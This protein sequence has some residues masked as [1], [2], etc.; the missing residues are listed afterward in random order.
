MLIDDLLNKAIKA[1]KKPYWCDEH[2]KWEKEPHNSKSVTVSKA[3]SGGVAP[4][5]TSSGA[6]TDTAKS[7]RM[8]AHEEVVPVF[9]SV[10]KDRN[11][12]V[13]GPPGPEDAE[14]MNA[15]IAAKKPAKKPSWLS[16]IFGRNKEA[17]M[18]KG[19]ENKPRFRATQRPPGTGLD[20]EEPI[21]YRPVPDPE[22]GKVATPPADATDLPVYEP[23]TKGKLKYPGGYSIEDA[24]LKLMKADIPPHKP[25]IRSDIVGKKRRP[26][27]D[28]L[29][30]MHLEGTKIPHSDEEMAKYM[31]NHYAGGTDTPAN[32]FRALNHLARGK[33]TITPNSNKSDVHDMPRTPFHKIPK[34]TYPEFQD[35]FLTD[36]EEG[37]EPGKHGYAYEQSLPK[38]PPVKENLL[39]P[40]VQGPSDNVVGRVSSQETYGRGGALRPQDAQTHSQV[41]SHESNMNHFSESQQTLARS[42]GSD[43]QSNVEQSLLKLMKEHT[44]EQEGRDVARQRHINAR[45]APGEHGQEP[46]DV[47]RYEKNHEEGGTTHPRNVFKYLNHLA[48]ERY[49]VEPVQTREDATPFDRL[50]YTSA[51]GLKDTLAKHGWD[52]KQTGHEPGHGVQQDNEDHLQDNIEQLGKTHGDVTGV[53]RDLPSRELFNV[54]SKPMTPERQAKGRPNPNF[55]N[56]IEKIWNPF[57]R[58]PKPEPSQH[59]KEEVDVPDTERLRGPYP[60]TLTTAGGTTAEHALM[61]FHSRDTGPKLSRRTNVGEALQDTASPFP[62]VPERE[63]E[64]QLGRIHLN[65]IENSILKIMKYGSDVNPSEVGMTKHNALKHMDKAQAP[66]EENVSSRLEG[67]RAPADTSSDA[68]QELAQGLAGIAAQASS[69]QGKVGQ[70]YADEAQRRMNEAKQGGTPDAG[71]DPNAALAFKQPETPSETA[72]G[73]TTQTQQTKIDVPSSFPDP[74]EKQPDPTQNQQ[75]QT[76][77]KPPPTGNKIQV[78]NV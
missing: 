29:E 1:D 21:T 60:S 36:D 70:F 64:H 3:M 67:E 10:D 58:K 71:G 17:S 7:P 55:Y 51:P 11:K 9:L 26:G 34:M 41:R 8:N 35:E 13:Q 66:P 22:T 16:R 24:L 42:H 48:D 38:R 59:G 68:G 49:K 5:G 74:T 30:E 4:K 27:Q 33:Y 77:I 28:R 63:S 57:K 62:E 43:A 31:E 56:S 20:S 75:N 46:F 47:E 69:G 18:E 72:G 78:P 45:M 61:P 76:Q 15:N 19:D 73:D 52:Y 37:P 50:P 54:L 2:C 65:S 14:R 23:S 32:H 25:A 6:N 44:P 40:E 39:K 12:D 53:E